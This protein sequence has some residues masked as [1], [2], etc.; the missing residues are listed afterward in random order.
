M[1]QKA[2]GYVERNLSYNITLQ[3]I[4][5]ELLVSTG[6]FSKC[7]KRETGVGFA[8]YVTMV[9]MEKARVLLKNPKNR[10]NEVAYMLGY[11]DYAYFFQVFKK[12][13]G[14]APSE[15]KTSGDKKG[16]NKK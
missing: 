13:F 3:D 16:G 5:E 12:Q 15:I 14:Y 7:F 4:C 6:H 8:S 2:I 1:V 9:K 11:N 10:V